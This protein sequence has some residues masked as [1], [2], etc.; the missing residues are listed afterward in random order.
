MLLVLILEQTIICIVFICR[1]FIVLMYELIST[2][3]QV[4]KSEINKCYF[5][6]TLVI[7]TL[8]VT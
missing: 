3:S 8:T 2:L 4:D 7:V 5:T 1:C 6:I